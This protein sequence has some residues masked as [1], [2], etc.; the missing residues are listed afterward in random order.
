MDSAQALARA[1]RLADAMRQMAG[2]SSSWVAA[3][4][5]A[6]ARATLRASTTRRAA[7][8]AVTPAPRPETLAAVAPAHRALQDARPAI[9]AV[10]GEY[11]R[12][13]ASRDVA[14]VRRVYPA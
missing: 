3:E 12:A 13:I 1:G 2:A 5:A 4:S 8:P 10:I 7:V 14:A 9:E 11:A 6:R